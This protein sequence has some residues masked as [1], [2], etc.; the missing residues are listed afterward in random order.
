MARRKA[1]QYKTGGPAPV[2]AQPTTTRQLRSATRSQQPQSDN[3]AGAATNVKKPS[4]FGARDDHDPR[5]EV[6]DDGAGEDEEVLDEQQ[7]LLDQQVSGDVESLRDTNKGELHKSEESSAVATGPTLREDLP[8][9]LQST[10]V[11]Q[12]GLEAQQAAHDPPEAPCHTTYTD[13]AAAGDAARVEAQIASAN[14]SPVERQSSQ[15]GPSVIE[16]LPVEVSDPEPAPSPASSRSL[17]KRR[18]SSGLDSTESPPCKR[19]NRSRSIS[20]ERHVPAAPKP[21][22]SGDTDLDGGDLKGEDLAGEGMN[23]GDSD[24]GG[25]NEEDG[26]ED[27]DHEDADE[28]NPREK[29]FDGEQEIDQDNPIKTLTNSELSYPNRWRAALSSLVNRQ[30]SRSTLQTVRDSI[31]V[32]QRVYPHFLREVDAVRAIDLPT[33]PVEEF[34]QRVL[35]CIY[36]GIG[37]MAG[38]ALAERR[39]LEEGQK[40]LG[41]LQPTEALQLADEDLAGTWNFH[42]TVGKGTSGY[43]GRW[44][45]YDNNGKISGRMVLKDSYHNASSWNNLNANTWEDRDARIPKEHFL[46]Q[47][48]NRCPDSHNIVKCYAYNVHHAQRMIRFYLEDCP[49]GDLEDV[50]RQ[51]VHVRENV[52][53]AEGRPVASRI[54]APVLWCVFEALISAV[55]FMT[56]GSLPM[57]AEAPGWQPILHRDIKTD[58][59]FLGHSHGSIW[60][61]MPMPKLGDF[62]LTLEIDDETALKGSGTDKYMAPERRNFNDP[63][64]VEA[65]QDPVLC[66]SSDIWSVGRVMYSL[67][68]LQRQNAPVVSELITHPKTGEQWY[69]IEDR[70]FYAM[71]GPTLLRLVEHCLA[72]EPMGRPEPAQLWREI[73]T[74]VGL[75]RD[76]AMSVPPMKTEQLPETEKLWYKQAQNNLWVPQ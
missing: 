58:N 19:R 18:A 8:G 1:T 6:E 12:A 38:D 36:D 14:L 37:A 53:D 34:G 67:M 13:Q 27:A 3:S 61:G 74:K 48:L 55:C 9:S 45:Q 23:E 42:G 57:H 72:I 43:A 76:F 73:Q 62:G 28:E 25:P 70:D 75:Y 10:T 2:S 52:V 35:R 64:M 15:D 16:Q 21:N 63:S 7:A 32:A 60:P 40:D 11:S 30:A 22:H 51:H 41:F 56:A 66:T 46:Q 68:N 49:H 54:P 44:I 59:V 39:R 69:N 29:G 65:L 26:A 50:I 33:L 47:Q 4:S 20:S 71:T 5:E 31:R 24:E 17:L